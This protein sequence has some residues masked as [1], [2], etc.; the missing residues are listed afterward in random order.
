MKYPQRSGRA[1]RAALA[2]VLMFSG[3]A[4]AGCGMPGAPLPPSLQLPGRVGDLSAVRTGNQVVLSWSM[5]KRDTDKVPLKGNVAVR[6]CRDESVAAGCSAV[7]TLQVA[8]DADGAFTDTL[9]PALA[10]GA[11]RVLIYFVEL[12]N[13]KGRTAGLSNGAQ[14]LAGEA[15]AAVDGLAAEMRRDGVL[16][17]WAPEPPDTAPVAVQL[18]RKLVSPPAPAPS[19]S[20]EGPLAPRPEP[21]ER[22]LL[23][24]PGPQ[25]GRA[26]D[27]SIQFGETYEYRA[28]RVARV[29]VNGETLELAGPL[30]GA[31]RIAAVNVFPPAVPRGLAAVAT[32][33]AEGAGPAIDLNWQPGTE[34]DLAGYVVYRREAGKPESNWQRISPAQPVAAPYYHDANVQSGHTYMYAVGAVDQQGHESARSAETEETVPGP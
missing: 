32:A 12:D 14:V 25:L 34:A 24:E 21:L 23:V 17:R 8:P 29:T 4:L 15:P 26:L 10:E 7:A 1:R 5:P 18:V 30:S 20:T 33:G 22:T 19:R 11:P 6:I 31:V 28:Q 9:P 16:L 3:V 27:S 13:R 2:F